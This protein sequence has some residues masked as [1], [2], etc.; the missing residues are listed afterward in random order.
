MR[1]WGIGLVVLGGLA[2]LGLWLLPGSGRTEAPSPAR[3]VHPKGSASSL[4]SSVTSQPQRPGVGLRITGTVVDT[5]GAPVA[6]A[7]VSASRPVPGQ[8]LSELPCPDV[9]VEAWHDDRDSSDHG[10]KLADCMGLANELILDL[11]T[12]REGEAPVH[13]EA[14]TAEDGSFVLEGLPQGPLALWVLSGRGAVMRPAIP[15]GTEGVELVLESGRGV[16][17]TVLG[18]GTPLAG[19]RVTVVTDEHTRFF[20]ATTDAKGRFHLG[21]IPD[22]LLFL[23]ASSEGWLPELVSLG[24]ARKVTL[25]R[26]HPLAG[27]VLFEGAPVPGVEVRVSSGE[28]LPG[29]S[30]RKATSDAQGRFS[31]V[32]PSGGTRALSAAHDGRYAIARV[33]LSAS[34]PADI[35][36]ELGSALQVEGLVS[37]EDRRPVTGARVSLISPGGGTVMESVTGADG[38]YRAGPVEPGTW[39]FRVEADRYVD[40]PE[41]VEHTLTQGMGRV[42]FTLARASSVTGRVTDAEGRPLKGLELALVLPGPEHPPYH[43]ELQEKTWADEDGRF[44]LDAKAPG[45]YVIAVRDERFRPVAFPVQTPSEDVHLTMR[46]GASVAGTVVDAQGLPLE[47]FLVELQDPELEDAP[48][49]GPTQRTDEQGRFHLQGVKPGHYLLLA[50]RETDGIARR[51]WR[52]VTLGDGT[53]SEVELRVE[54]ER[55]LSGLVVDGAGRPLA[56]V[57]VRARPPQEDAPHWKTEGRYTHHGPPPGTPTGPDGRFLLRHLTEASY[58]V[59]VR[60][61]GYS[62]VPERSTGAS[63]SKEELFHV[64]PD[65]GPLHVVLERQPHIVGRVVG[66]DGVPLLRFTLNRQEPDG[67]DGA[68]ALPMSD[69]EERLIVIEASGMAPLTRAVEQGPR[70]ADVDLGVLRMTPGRTVRGRVIDAETSAPVERAFIECSANAWER[71]TTGYAYSA[72]DGTFELHHVDTASV[73]LVVQARHRYLE[74]RV[75]LASAPEELT[76]RMEAGARVEVTVKD[77]QGRLRAASVHFHRGDGTSVDAEAPEGRL[78]QRGLEPGPYTVRLGFEEARTGKAPFFHP[79]Q[80]VVPASGLLQVAFAEAEGGATVKLRVAGAP[81]A[82]LYLFPGSIPVPRRMEDMDRWMAQGF[83]Y[84]REEGAPTFRHV[85]EGRATIFLASTGDDVRFHM[86]ELD[87]PAGGTVS[88]ELHPVWRPFEVGDSE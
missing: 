79:R 71:Y 8:T 54:A 13:G 20:D 53:R 56:D 67:T 69:K 36:L 5:Y 34:T 51:A 38:H 86:E 48:S 18:D 62:L 27:R 10:R 87:V 19:A 59:S 78:V 41:P 75:P 65:T 22:G 68:F 11:V 39:S 21:P 81:D 47:D 72:A 55:T 76:V 15:A 26:P 40:L 85:P 2:L 31:F 30:D 88:R 64:G 35:V 4:R 83:V 57:F 46:P 80:V 1:R 73:T 42:D 84:R 49:P 6:G 44:L 24:K 43:S 23:V 60:K 77:A 25:H 61:D 16:E 63:L 3:T 66:P 50:S 82:H 37:D 52:E 7:R 14:T 33:E 9:P 29:V 32:L 17:G 12:A 45:N 70:G 58:D 74:Q 28:D